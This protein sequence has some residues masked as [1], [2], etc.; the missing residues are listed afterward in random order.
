[1]LSVDV[2]E[3]GVLFFPVPFCM[4]QGSEAMVRVGGDSGSSGVLCK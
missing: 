3:A 4:D 2:G 1:M